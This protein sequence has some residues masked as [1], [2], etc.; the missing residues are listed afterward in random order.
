MK[1]NLAIDSELR[2]HSNISG[3]NYQKLLP[4]MAAILDLRKYSNIGFG[5]LWIG[6]M[7]SENE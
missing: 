7:H 4:V 5:C 1:T 3:A 6:Y 2:T